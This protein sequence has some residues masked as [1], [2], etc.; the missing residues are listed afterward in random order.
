MKQIM[1][2]L[3]RGWMLTFRSPPHVQKLY[4]K[5]STPHSKPLFLITNHDSWNLWQTSFYFEEHY[6]GKNDKHKSMKGN[7]RYKYWSEWLEMIWCSMKAQLSSVLVTTLWHGSIY[8]WTSQKLSDTF[9]VHFYTGNRKISFFHKYF[10]PIN[11]WLC[12]MKKCMQMFKQWYLQMMDGGC[13][14]YYRI[15]G[16]YWCS[17]NL[18][19]Q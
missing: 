18:Q 14:K 5:P 3:S 11:T 1:T 7:W 12:S 10:K 13:T 6:S 8:T 17:I 16:N 9:T 19:F 4:H 15:T 2:P